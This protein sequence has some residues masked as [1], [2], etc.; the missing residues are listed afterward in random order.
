MKRR[1]KALLILAILMQISSYFAPFL[2]ANYG[3]QFFEEGVEAFF[4]QGIQTN[5]WYEFYAFFAP[6]L[7]FP[8]LLIALFKPFPK[9][10][11]IALK[12]GLGLTLLC[13]VLLSIILVSSKYRTLGYVF[14][15]V[16]FCLMYSLL[17]FK[18]ENKETVDVD[19]LNRHLIENET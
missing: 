16:S 1:T 17:F 9:A 15:T 7:S 8:I 4:S 10:M 19:D 14:W 3:Y 5:S 6:I 2:H 11:G 13:P 18:K 12:L